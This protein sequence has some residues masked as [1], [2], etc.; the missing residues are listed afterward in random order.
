MVSADRRA[1][2]DALKVLARLAPP[3]YAAPI[4]TNVLLNVRG[5]VLAA[6]ATDVSTRLTAKLPAQGDDFTVCASARALASLLKPESK[7]SAGQ[8]SLGLDG[9]RLLVEVDGVTSRLPTA[10]PME[11]PSGLGTALEWSLAG[12]CGAQPLRNAIDWVLPASSTDPTRKHLCTILIDG[13]VVAAT[14]GHRLHSA[15]SPLSP[16]TPLL[17]ST[18]TANILRRVLTNGEQVIMARAKSGEREVLRVRSG[19]WQLESTLVDAQFPPYKHVIPHRD[20]QPTH[21]SVERA[22]FQKALRKVT[23]AAKG[24]VRLCVNG[25]ITVSAEDLD[26]GEASAAVPVIETTHRGADLVIGFDPH[27]LADAV[28]ASG[29]TVEMG[30]G[31]ALDPLRLDLAD[32]RVA[33]VMPCK[34]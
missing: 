26:G 2:H 3:K 8:V 17:L 33:V 5:G 11:F 28:Q 14:D 32:G 4:V 31:K 20:D 30:F 16:K 18:S 29:D 6:T 27:Y 13:A 19:A 23:A 34:L 1:L 24:N 22:L 25:A 12:T 15:P 9:N 7:R 21:L 10:N